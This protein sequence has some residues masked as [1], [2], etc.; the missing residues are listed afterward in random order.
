MNTLRF[1]LAVTARCI[2]IK[3]VFSLFSFFLVAGRKSRSEEHTYTL[4]NDAMFLLLD[5]Q[6][7]RNVKKKQQ[8][9]QKKNTPDFFDHTVSYFGPR[10]IRKIL[11]WN[12]PEKYT[13]NFLI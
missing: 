9:Q 8:K 11:L 13:H 4:H 7:R 1:Q 10:N 3:C 2:H 5:F 12:A 6:R